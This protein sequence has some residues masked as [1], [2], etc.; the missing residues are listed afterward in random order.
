[1]PF[2]SY[3]SAIDFASKGQHTNPI[4]EQGKMKQTHMFI[5][6]VYIDGKVS[7]FYL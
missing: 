2:V 7:K 6:Y 3:D 4:V 1:M 5:A